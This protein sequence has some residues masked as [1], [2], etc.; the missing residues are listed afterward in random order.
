[1]A[2]T[3]SYAEHLKTKLK[4]FSWFPVTVKEHLAFFSIIFFVG[5]VDVPVLKDCWN[6]DNYFGQEFIRNSGMS[7]NR[8]LN[9]LTAIDI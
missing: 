6:N 3:N 7:R 9:I 1:M 8:F 4:S 5:M 2:N